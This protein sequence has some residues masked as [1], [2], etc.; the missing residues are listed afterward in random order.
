MRIRNIT[1]IFAPAFVFV[2]LLGAQSPNYGIGR[3]A[4]D[5]EIRAWDISIP[6]DGTGLPPGKGTAVEGKEVYKLRCAECH[7][8]N[9]EG[10]DAAALVGGRGTLRSPKPLKTVGSYWPHATTL[11]D[12]VNRAMPFDR[13]GM[14]T[15]AQVYAVVAY[16]LFLNE[17]IEEKA[18]MNAESL[19]SVKM[20]NRDAF[21]PAS[22]V[23][24]EV[25]PSRPGGPEK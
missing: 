13:P 15:N 20:P 14:L 11:W 12:Y 1:A 4:S 16:V 8:E 23:D 24:A 10:G 2:T 5:E 7:G 21:V 3:V 17:I 18:E 19:P 6:P 9:G 25:E 22:E